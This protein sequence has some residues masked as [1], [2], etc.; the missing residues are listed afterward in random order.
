MFR[1]AGPD[2]NDRDILALH[3]LRPHLTALHRRQRRHAAGAPELTP[4]QQQILTLVADGHTNHHIARV[5]N[6]SEATVRKHLENAYA[7]L[8]VTNRTAA[9][10][11]VLPQAR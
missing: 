1:T 10:I 9:A 4:R 6:L 7:R 8:G 3:L 2:F 11:K 5:L